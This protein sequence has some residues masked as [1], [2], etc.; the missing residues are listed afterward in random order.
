MKEYN[1]LT[2]KLLSEGYT[3]K[4]YPD[5]VT[6]PSGSY[7]EDPLNNLDGGFIYTEQH[8]KH[9]VLETGCGLLVKGSHFC[10]GSTFFKGILWII[11]NDNQLLTCP[12]RKDDCN[13][14]NPILDRAS[15]GG[16]CKVLRCDCHQT[17][18]PYDYEQSVDKAVDDEKKEM[19]RKY[20]EFVKRKGGHVCHWHTNYNYWTKEWS[21]NYDPITC[22]H[23]CLNVGR[24]CDLTHQPISKKKGNVFY[25]VKTSYIRN[26]GTLFDGEEVVVI[27]KGKRLFE[28]ARS[29]TICEEAAK[30]CAQDILDKERMNVGHKIAVYG[31]KVEILNIRAEFRE[32][33][34]L[35][36]DLQDIKAGIHIVHD[37][38]VKKQEKA[39]KKYRRQQAYEKKIK[40]LEKKLLKFGYYNLPENSLDRIHADKWIG[41]ARIAELENLR[42]QKL[43]EERE[44]PVQLNMFDMMEL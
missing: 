36:Q 17:D 2:Q 41:Y 7:G 8:K 3:A 13:L 32:G 20:D 5:Y 12:Y 42:N 30:R 11:E 9:M 40:R 29:I 38:D 18:K 35:M 25:D 15:G 28:T 14:R 33:R 10:P 31:W 43:K 22:G 19:N 44:K 37:S 39:N 23:Y 24:I 27:H 6:I 26:S 1:L 21:Q 4:C 16:L 34:D